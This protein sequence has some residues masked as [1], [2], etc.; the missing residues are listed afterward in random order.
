MP[1]TSDP[2]EVWK[3]LLGSIAK[4]WWIHLTQTSCEAFRYYWM[5]TKAGSSQ[6]EF[7]LLSN[8]W[9][10]RFPLW[11]DS[12]TGC[13][14]GT[15]QESI[16]MLIRPGRSSSSSSSSLFLSASSR[17][18]QSLSLS[19][20][21]MKSPPGMLHCTGMDKLEDLPPDLLRHAFAVADKD[22]SLGV[23]GCNQW[24]KYPVM[25]SESE[26]VWHPWFANDLELFATET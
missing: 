1:C 20:S 8:Y 14:G 17:F 26:W 12:C 21:E 4:G 22:K 11:R 15:V 2:F 16:Q 18:T 23:P 9:R 19:Q 10:P 5:I 6:L 25:S 24:L 7:S 3:V 13:G